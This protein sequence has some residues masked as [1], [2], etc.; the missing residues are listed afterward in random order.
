MVEVCEASAAAVAEAFCEPS[1]F[2]SAVCPLLA[3]SHIAI[4]VVGCC[5]VVGFPTIPLYMVRRGAT[6]PPGN[7]A[8]VRRSQGVTRLEAASPRKGPVL[9]WG[10]E[11][12]CLAASDANG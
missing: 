8:D 12:S 6:D 11:T 4:S 9:P 10:G 5:K 1:E 7:A 2:H 3:R